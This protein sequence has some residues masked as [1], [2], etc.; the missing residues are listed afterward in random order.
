MVNDN[1]EPCLA[2]ESCTLIKISILEKPDSTESDYFVTTQEINI[3]TSARDAENGYSVNTTGC[4]L[5]TNE[6]EGS[7][8]DILSFSA[9]SD[10]PEFAAGD[11]I[12]ICGS[13]NENM[14]FED[15]S[16]MIIVYPEIIEQNG[17]TVFLSDAYQVK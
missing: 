3:T 14:Q 4:Y 9:K 11:E 10:L 12:T 17:D 6:V 7:D 1:A 2:D 16:K 13:A 15:N 5:L 8:V